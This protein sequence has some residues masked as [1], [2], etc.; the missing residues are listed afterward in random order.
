MKKVWLTL[1][2][3]LTLL[4]TA[5]EKPLKREL[6]FKRPTAVVLT[7]TNELVVLHPAFRNKVIELIQAC[8]EE[9]IE[10]QILET[11][12]TPELQNTY[13]KRG[14]SRLSGGESKHQYG[15]AVDIVPIINNKQQWNNKKLWTKLG[16]LG[17]SL[18]LQ[19]GG[20]WKKLYDPG[21]FEWKCTVSDL[22]TGN[23]PEQ[24][25]KILIPFN[26]NTYGE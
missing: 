23:L 12:R 6:T 9:G 17:E 10:V 15:L 21:H 19:W 13:K 16:K 20:K 2:L 14:V 24:P 22:K 4:R 7:T 5:D 11:Y 26:W 3:L 18:G 8:K 25:N 1:L